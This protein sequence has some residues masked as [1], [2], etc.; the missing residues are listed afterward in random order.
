VLEW[1]EVMYSPDIPAT[2]TDGINHP[3]T[4]ADKEF[5]VNSDEKANFQLFFKYKVPYLLSQTLNTIFIIW[6]N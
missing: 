3:Q 4:I 5:L 6:V 1:N 2:Y